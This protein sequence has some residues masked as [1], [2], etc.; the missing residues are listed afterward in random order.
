MSAMQIILACVAFSCIAALFVAAVLGR[1]N[2]EEDVKIVDKA[3]E[4]IGDVV[5][6]RRVL[7]NYKD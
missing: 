7:D 4:Q 5:D 6:I 2:G 1:L 3:P